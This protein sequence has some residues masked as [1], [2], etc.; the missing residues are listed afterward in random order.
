MKKKLPTIKCPTCS[1]IITREDLKYSQKGET[2]YNVHFDKK[3]NPE[4]EQDEF[5]NEE[6]GKYYHADCGGNWI[7]YD[8]LKK[9]G[10]KC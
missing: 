4:Y 6:G 9:L 7:D 3:G 8:N 10:V 5:F 1:G 2:T